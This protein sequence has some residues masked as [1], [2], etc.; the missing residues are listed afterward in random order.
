MQM[1]EKFPKRTIELKLRKE[2][3][4]F[5]TIKGH[6]RHVVSSYM[7]LTNERAKLRGG[8]PITKDI[9]K[10]FFLIGHVQEKAALLIIK[11]FNIRKVRPVHFV[12]I[13]LGNFIYTSVILF[14]H[15]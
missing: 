8:H 5:S 11:I 2:G 13:V 15:F 4:C 10:W 1:A 9:Q 14:G 7:I 6:I 3:N 12:G